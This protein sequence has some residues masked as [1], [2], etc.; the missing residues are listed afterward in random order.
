[1]QKI[2]GNCSGTPLIIRVTGQELCDLEIQYVCKG[3]VAEGSRNWKLMWL[4]G[5][6]QGGGNPE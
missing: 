4:E 3:P 2:G 5:R 1:M 6:V